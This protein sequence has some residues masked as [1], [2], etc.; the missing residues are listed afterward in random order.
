M[1]TGRADRQLAAIMVIDVVGYSRLMGANEEGTLAVLKNLKDGVVSPQV[2]AYRGRIVKVMG[3]GAIIIFA[4]IV[5]AVNAAVAVQQ[6]M[7]R[8][9]PRVL[10][11][12]AMELRIG[13]NLGDVIREGS[14][15]Y[16]DGV[17]IAARLQEVC[18]PGALAI[19]FSSNVQDLGNDSVT[20]S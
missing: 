17:N 14:D 8:F 13:L 18:R 15:I 20:L 2:A 12:E 7:A 9:E 6:A 19:T 10:A 3:D 11:H 5:D 1:A 16:G 4:S